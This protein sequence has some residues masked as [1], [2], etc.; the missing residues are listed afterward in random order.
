MGNY[1]INKEIRISVQEVLDQ[2]NFKILH[3][4]DPKNTY[5]YT[6]GVARI[7]IEL[8]TSVEPHYQRQTNIVLLGASEKHYF[9]TL[10]DKQLKVCL[11]RI[12]KLNPPLVILNKSFDKK[13]LERCN[14]LV[15][16][17]KFTI[18]WI[19][20]DSAAIYFEL[21]PFVA[22]KIV[23]YTKIHGTLMNIYGDGVLIIGDSGSGK[24]EAAM[25][26]LRAGHLFVADDAVEIY[27]FG[28][29]LYGHPSNFAKHFI[30]V[31]GLGI[32]N[33]CRMFGRQQTLK[34]TKI[35]VVCKLVN[36]VDKEGHNN[37]NKMERIGKKQQYEVINGVRIPMYEIPLTVGRSTA[38]L[39]EAAVS[40][41]KL[42]I[43]G[44]YSA[45]EYIKNFN[46][47]VAGKGKKWF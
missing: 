10:T 40:D 38:T 35:N 47:L 12:K 8:A 7:G 31:R 27:N 15:G 46:D 45:D 24:S 18:A 22:R 20:M 23:P 1:K 42:K 41:Y 4:G 13:S 9:D 34:E 3:K 2:F 19:D 25:E 44:Y 26:L 43:N 39:I 11:N 21:S 36:P 6:S 37:L 30:E 17:V 14:R 16:E 33:V 29:S 5:I 32:L 28:Q